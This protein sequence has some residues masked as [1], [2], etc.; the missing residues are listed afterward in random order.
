MNTITTNRQKGLRPTTTA[1]LVLALL[2]VITGAFT[3]TALT[4]AVGAEK[5]NAVAE[6]TMRDVRAAMRIG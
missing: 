5:A 6:A 1:H 3:F 2:V 4:T